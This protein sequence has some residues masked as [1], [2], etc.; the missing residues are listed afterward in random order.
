[1]ARFKRMRRAGRRAFRAM[2]RGAKK[3][4]SSGGV[5][6]D[7]TAGALYGVARSPI[8]QA[9]TPLTSK[10][11]FGQYNDEV[12]MIGVSF[13]AKQFGP[14]G[15]AKNAGRAGLIIETA[16][17]VSQMTAGLTASATSSPDTSSSTSW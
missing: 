5:M 8:A 9:I 14:K 6:S 4:Y 13:L 12:G 7:L 10:L 15:L 11:P 16:A 17:L 3:S 1:M 2:R